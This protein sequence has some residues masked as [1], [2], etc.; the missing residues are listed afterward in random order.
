MNE[1]LDATYLP[2]T[3]EQL[4]NHIAPVKRGGECV[5]NERHLRYYKQSVERYHRYLAD[6]D[7]R[8]GKSLSEMRRPCQIEKDERFWVASCMMTIFHHDQRETI[9][10]ELLTKTYG[11]SPPLVSLESWE[12]CLHGDLELF[13]ESNLPSPSS[14]KTWLS[15]KLSERHFIPYVLHSAYGKKVLEGPSHVNAL[16]MNPSNGF[17]VLVEAKVLSDISYQITYDVTRNQIAR[18]IDVILERNDSLCDPLNR[19]DP[20]SSLFLLLTPELFKT[21]PSSRLYGY[22]FNEYKENPESIAADLPHRGNLN[23]E[24]I[25]R[26][27][28]W[29]TWEDFHRTNK[30]C[31]LWLSELPTL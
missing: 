26:R 11:D 12:E 5:K 28:G 2:F 9:L 16:L 14:Y 15:R 18:N 31:C 10:K 1:V 25:S 27:L 8:K 19:R 7:D 30:D 4:L 21:N 29:L 6:N 24:R 17:A 13:F 3:E 20:S 23:W 22:K